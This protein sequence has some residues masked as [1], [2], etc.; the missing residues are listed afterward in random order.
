M[1]LRHTRSL[2]PRISII[3][4]IFVSV[5]TGTTAPKTAAELFSQTTVWT[6]HLTFTPD[7]WTAMEPKDSGQG[8]FGGPGGPR[9]P[10]APGGPAAFGP[11]NILAPAFL[12]DGDQNH[13]G[14]LSREEF[15]ALAHKWFDAWDK[16]STGHLERDQ[17][18]D[19]LNAILRL[20]AMGAGGG[21]PGTMLQGQPGMRNG[22]AGAM[23]IDFKYVHADLDFEGTALTNIGIRYKGNGTFLQSRGTL[24]RSLKLELDRYNENQKLAG[25]SKINL[26]NNVT[27]ASWMNEVLSHRLFR[28]AGVPAPRTAYARVYVTVPGKFDRQ[29]FGL[30]SIIEDIDKTFARTNFGTGKGAI[31]KPVTPNLF[32]FLGDDWSKYGQTYDPKT[33]LTDAQKK[34]I[35]DFARLVSSADDAEFAARL[36]G[37]LDLDEFARFMAV[38]VYLST[39]D[40]ILMMGQNFYVYLDA[41]SDKFEFLPW[42]LD[43]SFGQFPMGGS[44]EQREQL[45]IRH[46][47]RGENRFL[48]RVFKVD[49]FRELYLRKLEQYS[50][51][52]F[53]PERF[54]HQVDEVAAAIRP[55]VQ[56]ESETKLKRFD[57]VVSGKPVE[58]AGF[59]G[60]Q[61]RGGPPPGP[62]GG[63]FVGP[64]G[65]RPGGPPF[66]GPPGF[67]QPAKPIKGF[68]DARSKSVGEQL[69]GMDKGKT[70][71]DL[72]FG[73][74]G[75]P[76]GPG[77][78][79][80]GPVG[81]GPGNFL[82]PAFLSALDA[83][84]DG[85]LTRDELVTG[86]NKW[87]EAWDTDHVG[88]V[89]EKHLRDGLNRQFSANPPPPPGGFPPP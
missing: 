21:P 27:D 15:G 14:K 70:L 30:Y 18:R 88:L 84:K 54:H 45:S 16:K 41:R 69:T 77:R 85:Q 79:A 2:V 63:P 58:P 26:H 38:E 24:K 60:G 64:G 83:N 6:V 20:P 43:H 8:P 53:Q 73:P 3:A 87:F 52:I 44:Q 61:P 35:I 55:A 7:Q 1:L 19:G 17:I 31:L 67:M 62:Q 86:F 49:G 32:A 12:G 29:Y 40:S 10:G 11:G 89:D 33:K 50:K 51:T 74:P 4:G 66:G 25:V 5:A 65:D 46:P 75:G 48:E 36:G 57:T 28:D 39:L 78:G 9:G 71:D 34:R 42:D 68:V 76:G 59:F 13:D 82:A 72:G 47:W 37:Y 81:F 56:E 23:G 22:L 80:R